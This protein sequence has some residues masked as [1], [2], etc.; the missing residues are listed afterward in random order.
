MIHGH[1]NLA[2]AHDH[3]YTKIQRF[4][5][6]FGL[7]SASIGFMRSRS[8]AFLAA[9]VKFSVNEKTGEREVTKTMPRVPNKN[10]LAFSASRR[11]HWSNYAEN[12]AW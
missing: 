7:H 3:T 10:R 5:L 8:H 6:F 2:S 12:S 1:L 9:P 4:V 11:N